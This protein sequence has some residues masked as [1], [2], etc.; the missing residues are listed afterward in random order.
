MS[1]SEKIKATE[2]ATSIF[3]M[4]LA[5]YILFLIAEYAEKTSSCQK[6]EN[7]LLQG[8]C[9]DEFE[10]REIRLNLKAIIQRVKN[11]SQ[12]NPDSQKLIE[13]KILRTLE[14][15]TEEDLQII[16]WNS[17]NASLPTSIAYKPICWSSLFADWCQTVIVLGN[18]ESDELNKMRELAAQIM[19]YQQF[20]DRQSEGKVSSFWRCTGELCGDPQAIEAKYFSNL[21]THAYMDADQEKKWIETDLDDGFNWPSIAI[22][23]DEQGF[24]PDKSSLFPIFYYMNL[25][26]ASLKEQARIEQVLTTPALSFEDTK[27]YQKLLKDEKEKTKILERLMTANY[28]VLSDQEK[29]LF[30]QITNDPNLVKKKVKWP[31]KFKS[32]RP[33][34]FAYGA[35]RL[36]KKTP[37]K[38]ERPRIETPGFN[39]GYRLPRKMG[40][41]V[42]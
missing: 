36:D 5:C 15:V 32:A 39:P 27:F 21:V 20:A 30:E 18:K 28:R 23:L 13:Q 24:S 19:V 17:Q 22:L 33:A 9:Y 42:V 34:R 31:N 26:D 10:T 14:A 3:I 7:P 37:R 38:M 12:I 1:K 29:E 11:D 35:V 6:F 8:H 25:Y 2:T 41:K 40:S 4:M 16:A